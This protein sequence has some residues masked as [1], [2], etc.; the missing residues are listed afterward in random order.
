MHEVKPKVRMMRLF[1]S[2]LVMLPSCKMTG[3]VVLV[4]TFAPTDVALERVLIPM[5]SH[6]N[7]VEDVVGK[8]HV[9]VLAV[10]QEL[11]VLG[12]QGRGGRARLAISYARGARVGT[13]LAAWTCH[14]TV[15]PLAL[16]R[17]RLG[18]GGG[19]A[20][21]NA[22]G[23]G[24]NHCL[25]G[26]LLHQER[27]LVRAG[28]YIGGCGVLVFRGQAGQLPCE[29]GELIERVVDQEFLGVPG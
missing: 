17:P 29:S 18:A 25:G 16:G 21:R 26:G 20:L 3:E 9:T 23:H 22:C 4:F 2:V 14:G 24:R 27:L 6:V 8:V 10:V 7:G 5:T 15:V 13:G 12:R 19:G 11:R 1:P 28:H